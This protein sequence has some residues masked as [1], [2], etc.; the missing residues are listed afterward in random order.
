MVALMFGWKDLH[1]VESRDIRWE[2]KMGGLKGS[3]VV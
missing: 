1:S 2:L 3:T